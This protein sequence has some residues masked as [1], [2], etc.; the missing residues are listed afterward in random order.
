MATLESDSSV[1][2]SRVM[3]SARLLPTAVAL[4]AF[5]CAS[6]A[7]HASTVQFTALINGAQEPTASLAVWTGSFV[8]DTRT[9]TR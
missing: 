3:R 4:A 6:A 1:R 5:L 9:P 7:A 8:M 2:R